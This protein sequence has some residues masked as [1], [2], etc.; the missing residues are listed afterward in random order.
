MDKLRIALLQDC[1]RPSRQEALAA[2]VK[3]VEEAA[4]AGAKVVCTQELFLS[5]YF[6]DLQDAS[7]FELAEPVPGPATELFQSLAKRLDVVIV[8]SLFERR[9][10]GLHHNTAVVIDADGSLL[11]KYRKTHIPQDP[12]FE[13]KYY[14]A[15][16]D[17]GFKAWST[18]HG[19][20]GVIICWDQWYPESAR[21]TALQGADLILCPTA[22]GWLPEEKASIGE[23]QREAWFS[24]QRGHA[25]A[26]ACYFAAVNRVGCEGF[27]EFWGGSFVSDFYGNLVAKASESSPETLYADCD[28]AAQ[29]HRRR[30]WPFFRDRRPEAY[31]GLLK[32]F[33]DEL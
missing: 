26:N 30:T 6:C 2:T 31:S 1:A 16:G 32:R 11:G 13:E 24:V 7:R 21:L 5:R 22:I 3:R 10:P 20:I 28:F 14:F 12:H 4:A 9:A 23:S 17:T 18:K 19:R 25:A 29:E 15:P 27:I 33:G 8:L